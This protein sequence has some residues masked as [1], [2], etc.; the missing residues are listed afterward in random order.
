MLAFLVAIFPTLRMVQ[1]FPIGKY[2]ALNIIAWGAIEMSRSL[3]ECY[4]HSH[5]PTRSGRFSVL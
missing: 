5:L 3:Y 1:R 2:L 4:R